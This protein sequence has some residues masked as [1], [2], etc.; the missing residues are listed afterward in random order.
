VVGWAESSAEVFTWRETSTG[1]GNG[2]ERK[3][4]GKYLLEKCGGAGLL[5]KK[6]D[7]GMLLITP[8]FCPS[9]KG[10]VCLVTRGES[11]RGSR[12]KD[13]SF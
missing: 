12:R 7:R 4:S 5:E 3:F 8:A 11:Q 9:V 13:Q 10:V 2:L 6:P 1:W